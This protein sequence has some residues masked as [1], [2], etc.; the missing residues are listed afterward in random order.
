MKFLILM[1][2]LLLLV[3]CQKLKNLMDVPDKMDDLNKKMD[4][5]TSGME[6]TNAGM[7]EMIQGMGTTNANMR[8]MIRGMDATVVGINDQRVLLPFE[9]LMNEANY[10]RLS[11]IPSQLM[12][13]GQKLAQA[14]PVKDFAELVYLWLKEIREVNPIKAQDK[15]GNELDYTPAEISRINKVKL[16]RFYALQTVCGF[17]PDE[18]VTE[19]IDL[20]IKQYSRFEKVAY[21]ILMMRAQFIRDILLQES[22]LSEPLSSVGVIKEAMMYVEK[23]DFI[24]LLPF[25]SKISYKIDGFL[26]PMDTNI[27]EKLDPKM[28]R[29]L[30]RKIDLSVN[31]DFKI[32][33]EE[34]VVNSV[35]EQSKIQT[36]KTSD[37]AKAMEQLKSRLQYWEANTP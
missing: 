11:P 16:G 6:T 25:K 20:H 14:I 28:M 8:E 32:E 21:K 7:K 29:T 2:S 19:I 30:L 36:Q 9:Q 1:A 17:L 24:A 22:L 12:P 4:K 23:L 37:L 15:E 27:E 5:M 26:A 33:K 31:Q 34:V 13:W 10:E 3:S 35:E 18:K